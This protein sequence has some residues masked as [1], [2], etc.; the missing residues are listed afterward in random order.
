MTKIAR[1]IQ[2]SISRQNR[3]L[4]WFI[5]KTAFMPELFIISAIHFLWTKTQPLPLLSLHT[6]QDAWQDF[7]FV[8]I[9]T[10][11]LFMNKIL[12]Q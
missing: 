2:E 6:P 5:L 9:F 3:D 8:P 10:F 11:L 1:K 7:Q 12:I 4:F